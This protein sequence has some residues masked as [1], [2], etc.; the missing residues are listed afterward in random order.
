MTLEE[1]QHEVISS[2]QDS[3][4]C[5][6]AIVRRI[7]PTSINLRVPLTVGNFVDVFYNE[8]TGTAAFALIEKGKRIFGADNTG[9]WHIHLFEK[10]NQHIPIKQPLDAAAFFQMVAKHYKED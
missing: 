6:I 8:E 4:I 5:E 1:F 3:P 7:T 9:G 10:P 2:A